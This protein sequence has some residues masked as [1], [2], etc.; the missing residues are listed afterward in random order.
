MKFEIDPKLAKAMAR[1]GPRAAYGSMMYNFVRDGCDFVTMSADLGRSSGLERLRKE[2]PER[3]YNV[4]IAEQSLVAVAAGMAREGET[5]FASSFAPFISM[6][7]SEHVRVNLS[8]MR[9]PVKLIGLGSGFSLGF[10]GNTHYGLED[11]AIMNALPNL[12]IL[13]PADAASVGKAILAAAEIDGPVYIRLTGEAGSPN[14]YNQDYDLTVGKF[15][16]VTIRQDSKI[17]IIGCG[18]ILSECLEASKTLSEQ[19]IF[20]D[21]F[22]CHSIKPFDV[23]GA[24]RIFTRYPLVV[25]VEEHFLNGGLFSILSQIK[26]ANDYP[27]SLRGLGVDDSWVAPGERSYVLDQLGLNAQA[28]AAKVKDYLNGNGVQI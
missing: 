26:V 6:R 14:V 25:S 11:Y 7:A 27:G 19:D 21:V 1:M 20:A 17:A 5:V 16:P 23:E 18:A 10:L 2:F 9:E 13:C 3:F 22:D 24:R 15:N 4:G 8:Y 12:T 28:V